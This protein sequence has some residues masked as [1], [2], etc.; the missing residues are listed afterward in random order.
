[1][2]E[3]NVNVVVHRNGEKQNMFFFLKSFERRTFVVDKYMFFRVE[4]GSHEMR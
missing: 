1:M 4:K 3:T 2:F